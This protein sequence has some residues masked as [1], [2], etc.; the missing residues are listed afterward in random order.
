[1]I[2]CTV[3]GLLHAPEL[4]GVL[5]AGSRVLMI[6]NEAPIVA[7]AADGTEMEVERRVLAALAE[8]LPRFGGAAGWAA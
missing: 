1:V 7:V 6:P 2:D 3:E 8:H 4:P 5:A